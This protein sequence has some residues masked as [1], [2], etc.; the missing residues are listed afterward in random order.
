MKPSKVTWISFL[1]TLSALAIPHKA[2]AGNQNK[3]TGNESQPITIENR[4]EKI[5]KTLKEKE[6][7]LKDN[8][9]MEN[10]LQYP[11]DLDLDIDVASWIKGSRGSFLNR[12][13]RRG[14]FVNRRYGGG[15]I[16]GGR[17]RDR[18]GFLNRSPWRNGG[19]FLN[20]RYR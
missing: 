9:E 4:L 19:G 17:W 15:W 2:I 13:N 5:A 14:G 6:N 10:D 12:P 18:G 7:K 8:P 3:V 11:E 1:V 20:R 16:N